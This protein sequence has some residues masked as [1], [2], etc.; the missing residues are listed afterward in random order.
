MN[1]A[2]D[3]LGIAWVFVSWLVSMI[4]A[5]FKFL[6]RPLVLFEGIFICYFIYAMARSLEKAIAQSFRLLS[7]SN[8]RI[9]DRIRALEEKS[10]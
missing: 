3:I 4:E 6:D 2:A 9:E 7:E 8:N 5:F 1:D 10:S